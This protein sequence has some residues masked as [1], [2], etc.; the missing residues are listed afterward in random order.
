M[1]DDQEPT[2][3]TTPDPVAP[4]NVDG[5]PASTPLMERFWRATGVALGKYWQV[6]AAV[7][8]VAW[9]GSC[10]GYRRTGATGLPWG[11]STTQSVVRPRN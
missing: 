5:E 3:P 10:S 6:V 2:P 9:I 11:F 8:V 7:V 1:S 4:T